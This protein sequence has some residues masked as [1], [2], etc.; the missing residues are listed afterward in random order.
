[1]QGHLVRRYGARWV[2]GRFRLAGGSTRRRHN[3]GLSNTRIACIT[4][5]PGARRTLYV[6]T[7]GGGLHRDDNQTER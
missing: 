1:M 7:T 3:R 5:A 2:E 6:G 4:I